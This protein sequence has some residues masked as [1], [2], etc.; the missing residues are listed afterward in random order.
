ML[1]DKLKEWEQEMPEGLHE[2]LGG[3]RFCGQS[4][5]L[6]LAAPWDNEKCDE[7]ATEMCDCTQAVIYTNRKNRK[8]KVTKAIEENFGEKAKH[9]VRK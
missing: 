4:K 8:E 5:M 7:A 9:P 3:C 1:K 6:H 2:Q